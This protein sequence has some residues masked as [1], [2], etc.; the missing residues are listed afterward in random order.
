M[1]AVWS[2]IHHWESQEDQLVA[3]D[4]RRE[5][6]KGWGTGWEM[7]VLIVRV[8]K[9]WPCPPAEMPQRAEHSPGW[10]GRA[11]EG[12][13]WFTQVKVILLLPPVTIDTVFLL[14]I[15]LRKYWGLWWL[16]NVV[17]TSYFLVMWRSCKC[18]RETD[19]HPRHLMQCAGAGWGLMVVLWEQLLQGDSV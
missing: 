17:V 9:V 1:C 6:G 12:R 18:L 2:P 16:V 19:L 8:S 4:L 5:T 15:G 11:M 14:A 7:W 3:E 13:R 10:G